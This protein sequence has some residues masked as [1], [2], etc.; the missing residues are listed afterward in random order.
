ME[1]DPAT[2]EL[3]YDHYGPALYSIILQVI[4]DKALA[5]EILTRVFLRIYNDIRTYRI[6]GD[7]TLFGWMMRMAREVALQYGSTTPAGTAG[8]ALRDAGLLQRFANSLPERQ[9]KIFHLCYYK[10]LTKEAVARILGIAPEEVSAQLKETMIAFRTF[11][12]E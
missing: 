9:Q 5:E 10:G 1:G 6:S 11:L 7:M 2:R 12:G 4:S 8:L 3:V